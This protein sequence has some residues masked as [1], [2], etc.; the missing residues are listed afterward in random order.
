MNQYTFPFDTCEQPNKHGIAQPYSATVNL[1][2][3]A[4]VFYFLVQTQKSYTFF[5]LFSI[6]CF[7]GYA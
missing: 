5:L 6:L 7:D 3:C 2:N 4:I 1:V